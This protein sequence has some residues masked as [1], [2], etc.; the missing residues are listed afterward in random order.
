MMTPTEVIDL[1]FSATD[2]PRD[3]PL[4]QAL[5]QEMEAGMDGY[6]E[7]L[8]QSPLYPA[9]NAL[10]DVVRIIRRM[11]DTMEDAHIKETK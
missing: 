7:S 6:E 3:T 8:D 10:E 4:G 2:L 9:L 11:T 1:A 5:I